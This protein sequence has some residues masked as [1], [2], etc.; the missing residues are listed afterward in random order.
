MQRQFYISKKLSKDTEKN[1][2]MKQK[3]LTYTFYY[4]GAF[5]LDPMDIQ[6]RKIHPSFD[7]MTFIT[8]FLTCETLNENKPHKN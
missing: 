4:W 3:P 6:F 8:L 7:D 1:I 2:F 5:V